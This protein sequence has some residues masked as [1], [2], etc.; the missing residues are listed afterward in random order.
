M[1]IAGSM[2]TRSPEGRTLRQGLVRVYCSAI[3]GETIWKLA[4]VRSTRDFS[5]ARTVR[6]DSSGTDTED[7]HAGHE[8]AEAGAIIESKRKGGDKKDEES[9][10][11]DDGEDQDG[12]V[13]ADPGICHSGTENR[14]NVTPEGEE[15]VEGRGSLLAQV[16]GTRQDGVVPCI[17]HVVLPR[18]GETIV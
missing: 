12:V 7:D 4:S 8:T 13:A 6:L 14:S 11:V 10:N 15:V 9:A 2:M 1:V 16:Q 18:S 17:L 5:R 3:K